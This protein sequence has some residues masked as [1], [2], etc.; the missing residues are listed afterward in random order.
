MPWN[1]SVLKSTPCWEHPALLLLHLFFHCTKLSKIINCFFLAP[2]L[3]PSWLHFLPNSYQYPHVLIPSFSDWQPPPPTPTQT[4]HIICHLCSCIEAGEPHS[5]SNLSWS[6]APLHTSLF[7]DQ[8]ISPILQSEIFQIISIIFKLPT[9]CYLVCY[10][11]KY[12]K[13]LRVTY[14]NLQLLQSL[15]SRLPWHCRLA[16][17]PQSSLSNVFFHPS[18]HF[19]MMFP[20]TRPLFIAFFILCSP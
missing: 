5:D 16:P 11:N 10:F 15:P 19:C 3:D 9:L 7:L 20:M 14:L 8:L 6:S 12:L 2:F 4:K 17:S 18:F 13:W 1:C